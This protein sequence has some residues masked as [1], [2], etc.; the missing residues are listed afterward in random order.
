MENSETN[1]SSTHRFKKNVGIGS[2]QIFSRA[3]MDLPASREVGW[4]MPLRS[5]GIPLPD[6]DTRHLKKLFKNCDTHH[7]F[8]GAQDSYR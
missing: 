3:G 8:I 4:C 1:I 7:F 5:A 6:S 2:S